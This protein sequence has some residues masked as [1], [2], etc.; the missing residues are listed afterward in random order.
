MERGEGSEREGSTCLSSAAKGEKSFRHRFK[1]RLGFTV[2]GAPSASVGTDGPT[3]ASATAEVGGK[4]LNSCCSGTSTRIIPSP[5]PTASSLPLPPSPFIPPPSS[6]PLPP[7]PI[8]TYSHRVCLEW[9]R[10][11]IVFVLR[12][13]PPLA[14]FLMTQMREEGTVTVTVTLR[15]VGG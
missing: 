15:M 9:M 12:T 6:L 10:R 11:G 7:L 4:E 3:G 8:H 2:K 5:P 13:L 14:S 1:K